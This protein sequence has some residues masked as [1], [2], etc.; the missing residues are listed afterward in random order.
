MLA[1]FFCI[2]PCGMI[3]LRRPLYSALLAIALL[4]AECA[5]CQENSDADQQKL[6]AQLYEV[7]NEMWLLLSAVVDK[8]S[9]EASA[10]RFRQLSAQSSR[11]T[12]QL[13]DVESQAFQIET[14]D[15][16]T[17]RIAEAYENLSYE[18]ESLC[19]TQCYGSPALISAFL[20]AMRLGVFGDDSEN[21]L[22]M[23]SMTLSE[24]ESTT[25]IDRLLTLVEPDTELLHVLVK[26]QDEK[27]ASAAVPVLQ[28]IV[29]R[30]RGS[31]PDLQ[32]SAR[33]FADKYRDKLHEV[34][35]K[36][37]PLLWKI[38]TEIVRIVSLP[39]YDKEQF[40][41]FSDALDAVYESLGDTHAECFD[42]VFDASFRSDLDDAL[43]D[44]GSKF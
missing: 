42:S 31:L 3:Y 38:R 20:Y 25:E 36:L 9:A 32:L 30:L 16:D 22:K 26:V 4:S 5:V 6:S 28:A 35:Q 10:E 21:F 27:S 34:C 19:R 37:E 23:S 15:Q 7:T 2:I 41:D 44:S 33:N 13:F 8:E 1:A 39:G 43:H 40:D 12:D 24:K 29:G 17:Y 14:L 11:M 18:F